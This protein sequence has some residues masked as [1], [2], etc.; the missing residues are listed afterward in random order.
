MP[1]KKPTPSPAPAV[2]APSEVDELKTKLAERDATIAQSS[3]ERQELR[4]RLARVEGMVQTRVTAPVD[5]MPELPAL[6]DVADEEWEAAEGDPRALRKLERRQRRIDD[7]RLRRETNARIDEVAGLVTGV[8][9]AGMANLSETIAGMQTG[10]DGQPK[11]RYYSRFKAEIDAVVQQLDPRLRI[12]PEKIKQA[13]D[14]VV[15]QHLSEIIKEE[16]EAALRQ[17]A[18]APDAHPG[19]RSRVTAEDGDEVP[20]PEEIFSPADLRAINQKGGIEVFARKQGF[21]SA[22]EYLRD[23]AANQ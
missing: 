21:K 6:E 22:A 19:A 3:Q 16:R 8:G 12:Q 23:V 15:S 13:H 20:Q 11:L 9:L 17:A 5:A 18:D 7:E 14:Y 4:E 2:D 10:P 1:T